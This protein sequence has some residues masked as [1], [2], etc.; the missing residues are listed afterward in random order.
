MVGVTDLV[1]VNI[2][3]PHAHGY[4]DIRFMCECLMRP[5]T[6]LWPKAGV[7]ALSF[8][9]YPAEPTYGRIALFF[10]RRGYR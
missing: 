5:E 8:V 10:Y 9:C 1:V 3:V 7:A 2:L 6:A 4:N